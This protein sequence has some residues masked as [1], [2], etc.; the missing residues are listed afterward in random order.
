[1]VSFDDDEN[2]EDNGDFLMKFKRTLVM[3]LISLELSDF[4][5]AL[6]SGV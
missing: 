5:A 4:L 3:I 1:M 2:S 6:F